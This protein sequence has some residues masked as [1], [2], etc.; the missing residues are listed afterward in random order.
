[1]RVEALGTSINLGRE[2]K[3]ATRYVFQVNAANW[4][5]LVIGYLNSYTENC[6]IKSDCQSRT[7][8]IDLSH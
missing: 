1:M 7:R 6:H 5:P 3:Y 8:E 2:K 4:V